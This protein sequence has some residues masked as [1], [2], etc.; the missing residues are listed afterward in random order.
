MLQTAQDS[1]GLSNE[2]IARELHLSERTWRRWKEA[3]EV[4]AYYVDQVAQVLRLTIERPT[5]PARELS[6]YEA[7]LLRLEE[8]AVDVTESNERVAEKLDSL[9]RG[10]AVLQE[11]VASLAGR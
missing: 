2:G 4:P 5:P 10:L 1:V 3:G 8:L 7:R 9:V 6:D 11:Q